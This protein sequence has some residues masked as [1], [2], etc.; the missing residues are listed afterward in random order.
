M[1]KKLIIGLV[2]IA[3]I[4]VAGKFFIKQ[5]QE[6]ANLTVPKQYM[7]S[8]SVTKAINKKIEYSREFLA[9]VLSSNSAFIASKFSANIKKIYVNENDKVKKGDLLVSLDDSEI[10]AN[11]ASLKEQQRA[12]STDLQN[13][14]SI[15]QRNRKLL[16]IDAISKETVDN[17]EVMY[18]N[19]LSALQSVK[20]KIKQ[21]RST[22]RY[23][24]IKAPFSGRIGSKLANDGSLA[25]PGKPIL[26]LNSDDQELI[27]SFVDGDRPIVE[28]Q[29]VY[30]GNKLIGEISKRYDDAKNSLLVAQIKP[31]KPLPFA[32][33]SYK[34]IRVVTDSAKG[35]SVLNSNLLH[36]T[37]GIYI[38]VYK[39]NRFQ[40]Q[41]VE[42]ILSNATEAIIKECTSLQ[43][44]SA[45][46][47][48]LA[49]LP[50]YGEVNINGAK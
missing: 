3:I 47:A 17:S 30:I 44:A 12:L 13:T 42:I 10:Q 20:E 37:N 4:V 19:K 22:L 48:K 28:G 49:L 6:V 16:K 35:C 25:I 14:K 1:I 15:L 43:I 24:N 33:K 8:V 7:K 38:V 32:N 2:A 31:Y 21:T 11:L 36:K 9:Q 27:F 40:F 41:K 26:T 45:S 18:Q 50:S 29:K 39:E 46:E 5:K 23:L 34:T